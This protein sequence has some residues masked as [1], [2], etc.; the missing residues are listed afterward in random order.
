MNSTTQNTQPP[1]EP[2]T[3]APAGIPSQ[4]PRLKAQEPLTP[5]ERA[6]EANS[7]AMG[8]GMMAGAAAGAA[9][10][11]AVGGPVGV[12]VGGTVGAIAGALGGYA[13]VSA[14][15]PNYDYWRSNHVGQPGYV[16]GYG[17]EDDYAPA[18]RL[19]YQGRDRYQDQSWDKAEAQLRSDWDTLKGKSRL[20]WEQA[21]QASRDAWHR[22]ERALP[23]DAD[24]D[25]R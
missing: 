21:R 2:A 11:A 16:D 15:D 19:G 13:A 22:V 24:G 7:V 17:Y 3:A 5:E 1:E 18:Y 23:G 20:T 6:T 10:G 8:G 4:D 25:G 12:L 14:G 9:V